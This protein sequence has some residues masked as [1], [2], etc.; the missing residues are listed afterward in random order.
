MSW[1]EVADSALAVIAVLG[2]VFLAVCMVNG[3]P[4]RKNGREEDKE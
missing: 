4:G 1:P 2:L 3:W